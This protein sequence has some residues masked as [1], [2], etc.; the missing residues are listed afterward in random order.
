MPQQSTCTQACLAI[1]D[2]SLP[3]LSEVLS[4]LVSI[5]KENDQLITGVETDSRQVEAGQ[6]FINLSGKRAHR[7][8]ALNKQAAVVIECSQQR[9]HSVSK[10][11]HYDHQWLLVTLQ[12]L[13]KNHGKIIHHFHM[14]PSHQ[15]NCIGVTGTNGKT[16]VTSLIL[17]LYRQ[18]MRQC[19][20]VGSRGYGQ[21]V[22]SVKSLCSIQYTTPPA[23]QLA[24]VLS[25]AIKTGC[26]AVAMEVSSHA[27]EQARVSGITFDTLILTNVTRDH[28]DYH[29]NWHDYQAVKAKLFHDYDARNIVINLDDPTGRKIAR[30]YCGSGS[31][32]GYTLKSTG[33]GCGVE[34][35]RAF[36]I[37]SSIQGLS[38]KVHFRNQTMKL[39][40]KWIGDF[41]TQ[42]I[43]SALTALLASGY[44]LENLVKLIKDINP[45][46]GRMELINPNSKG[47]SIIIDY[48]HTPDALQSVLSCLQKICERSLIVIFGC[49]GNRDPG[50]R[51]IMGRVAEKYADQIILTDDNPR[52]ESSSSITNAILKGVMAPWDVSVIHDRQ[53]AI[54]HAIEHAHKGDIIL[55]AG[56]GDETSQDYH[57]KQIKFSDKKIANYLLKLKLSDVCMV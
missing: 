30:E 28:L 35:V 29:K 39:A 25:E 21:S 44:S 1:E 56:K 20:V 15:L 40:T 27:I 54:A 7:H 24:R 19:M 18:D 49:G 8:E 14:N 52:Q 12:E 11:S 3:L 5:D 32:W 46:A 34:V 42:N 38:M 6:I 17:E 10:H 23:T 4:G 51:E 47:P 45:I 31:V 36:D 50:K 26:E 16:S 13:K 33:I 9:Q 43:L 37:Q 57:H 48:A 2:T 41:N 53:E 22:S 55:I